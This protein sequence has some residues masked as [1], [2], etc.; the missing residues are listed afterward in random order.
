MTTS[1]VSFSPLVLHDCNM[2]GALVITKHFFL[3]SPKF[4]KL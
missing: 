2:C 3:F 4:Y 1:I